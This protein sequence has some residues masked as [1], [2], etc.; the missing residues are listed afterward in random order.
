MLD[1]LVRWWQR[2]CKHPEERRERRQCGPFHDVHW[3][4]R[5]GAYAI[6]QS[7]AAYVR[8]YLPAACNFD[9]MTNDAAITPR[10]VLGV[11]TSDR[12]VR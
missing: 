2:S 9:L 10:K 4:S 7:A 6:E 3:C 1:R 5:C 12:R 8:F 11:M